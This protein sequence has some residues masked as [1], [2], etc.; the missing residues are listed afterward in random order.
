MKLKHLADIA[1]GHSFRSRLEQVEGGGMAV[2]QMKDLTEDNRLNVEAMARIELSEVKARQHVAPDDIVFRS[3]GQTNTAVLVAGDVG[4]AVIAAPLLRIRP[5]ETVLPAYLKWFI[6]L[7]ATQAWL[8]TR[9][10][11]TA[12]RMISKQSLASLEVVVPSLERQR[13]IVELAELADEEQRLLQDLAG[14]RK[15]YIDGI[16]MQAASGSQS[17]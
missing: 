15:R 5:K 8:A 2:I 10:K 13:A 11:G 6:N 9:A 1:M 4:N 17:D 12:V 7:P 3:R 14:K 16:L